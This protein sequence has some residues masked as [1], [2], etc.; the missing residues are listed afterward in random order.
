M[1]NRLRI[2]L[3]VGNTN[4]D[5]KEERWQYENMRRSGAD[6]VIVYPVLERNT[7]AGYLNEHPDF[8]TIIVDTPL[9]EATRP[10]VLFDNWS[11]GYEITRLLLEGGHRKIAFLQLQAQNPHRS[12]V[13]RLAGFRRAMEEAGVPQAEQLVHNYFSINQREANRTAIRDLLTNGPFPS[14]I[15]A[16]NDVYAHELADFI[17]E[18]FPSALE[19]IVITGFD[20]LQKQEW[21]EAFLTTSPNFERMGERSVE[22]L[23]QI[24]EGETQAMPEL[25]LPCPIHYP[26]TVSRESIIFRP[27]HREAAAHS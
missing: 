22:M 21:R 3:Q 15:I 19:D 11:A 12:V 2:N 16:P 1:T 17:R 25:T 23:L 27:Q 24:I 9:A 10:T 13:D 8:P 26:P 5:A 6:G 20:N 4:W 18:E 7:G 14:A